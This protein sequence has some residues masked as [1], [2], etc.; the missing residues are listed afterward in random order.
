MHPNLS[1]SSGCENFLQRKRGK[2]RHEEVSKSLGEN[3]EGTPLQP[4]RPPVE[5]GTRRMKL[6]EY[7][8]PSETQSHTRISAPRYLLIHS[9]SRRELSTPPYSLGASLSLYS[10]C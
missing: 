4:D 2:E 1:A 3:M 9:L 7:S 8:D 5:E 6:R 10:L